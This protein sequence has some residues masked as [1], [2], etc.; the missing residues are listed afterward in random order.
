MSACC[1]SGHLAFHKYF[2][3]VVLCCRHTD[4]RGNLTAEDKMKTHT[5]F[6]ASWILWST[7]SP[8]K[9]PQVYWNYIDAFEKRQEC[10]NEIPGMLDSISRSK[11]T[12][13]VVSRTLST[14]TIIEKI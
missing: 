11:V 8:A 7:Y 6:A 1:G 2:R 14:V 10:E 4:C 13:K 9:S 12:R 3:P 5:L